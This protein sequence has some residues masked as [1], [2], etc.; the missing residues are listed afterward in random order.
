M[1]LTT[2]CSLPHSDEKD[3]SNVK[4]VHGYHLTRAGADSCKGDSGGA[5]VCNIKNKLTFVGIVSHGY[6][7]NM[8][9]YPGL[10]T[11]VLSFYDWLEESK[12]F[13]KFDFF[14]YSLVYL[15]RAFIWTEW[16]A[17]NVITCTQR[18]RRK[19]K[20]NNADSCKGS[21]EDNRDSHLSEGDD[22][23]VLPGWEKFDRGCTDTPECF[24]EAADQMP[25]DGK[26]IR[27]YH[28]IYMT[29]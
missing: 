28:I 22:D 3:E 6:K 25:V 17:C 23:F 18:R 10:Y 8:A 1:T 2:R 13:L 7:C 12:L 5:L 19:C 29:E 15:E 20:P 16:G 24:V 11:N 9:G 26:Y 4:N 27:L 14:R 21:A